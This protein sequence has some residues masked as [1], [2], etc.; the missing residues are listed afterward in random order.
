MDDKAPINFL[1]LTLEYPPFKGGVAHYYGHLVK[2][3]PAPLTVIDNSENKLLDSRKKIIS[4]RPAF[5][6]LRTVLKKRQADHVLIGQIL[7]LG[8][9][10]WLL[11]FVYKFHYTIFLH[12]YDLNS[13]LNQPFKRHLTLAILGRAH[14]I[15][16]ANS[17]TAKQVSGLFGQDDA[18]KIICVNPGI[19]CETITYDENAITELK[20]QHDLNNKIV[21]LS[22]GRLTKRK[23]F[24]MVIEALLLA[25]NERPE[26]VLVIIGQ[27]EAEADLRT[28]IADLDLNQ[29][30]LILTDVDDRIKNCWYKL[31][32]IFIM[33]ARQIG[34]DMEGFGIVYLEAGLAGKAV[35]AGRSGGV[36]DAVEHNINGLMVDP[37]DPTEIKEAIVKLA[38]YP[39]LRNRLGDEGRRRALKNFNWDK[40]AKKIFEFINS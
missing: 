38:E 13:A 15:I 17:R 22:V 30:V 4:W 35:I 31:A 32:D 37:Q 2:H 10:A 18:K 23:G 14:K 19:E 34:P 26:L 39:S 8:T 21:L 24:D 5:K 27:G 29:R 36:A 20:Q 16:C 25:K 40:Q 3:F 6:N 11:S 33:T 12:G 9:V 1:L 28:Q 7:P